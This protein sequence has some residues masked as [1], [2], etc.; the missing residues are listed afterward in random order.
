MTPLLLCTLTVIMTL[1]VSGIAKAK[2]RASTAAAIVN[3]K[4]DRWLP[5]KATS[6]LLPW[7]EIALAA[8]LFLVPGWSSILGGIAAVILFAAYWLVIARAVFTGNTASCNCFGG[9]SE[10]PVSAYTLTRN[11]AL[12]GA[13]IGA[14][15][16]AVR[17]QHSALTMI[18]HA[19]DDAWLWLLGTT[20]VAVALWS[21]YRSELLAPQGHSPAQEINPEF[22]QS[23]SNPTAAEDPGED[24]E[25][26]RH[27]IPYGTLETSSGVRSL[28]ELAQD[29]AR[30][31]IFL[32]PGCSP[33]LEVIPHIQ[34]WQK[35]LPQ[36][37]INPVVSQRS[38]V[39]QL[40]LPND[41]EVLVDPEFNTEVVFARA[42]PLAV[43]LGYDGMLAGGPVVGSKDVIEFMKDILVEFNAE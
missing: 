4:L 29:H 11:T 13:A 27:P 39:E 12:L 31:L 1:T 7:G 36:L 16:A 25:Y 14:L 5:L 20:L 21:M 32:S 9:A 10:A 8:W 38:E 34:Q 33:C 37:V 18:L 43:A 28:R 42:T 3:L 15:I 24:E 23:L 35:K 17:T 2:D 30:V 22:T 26:I 41:I 6:R 40:Q 19:N